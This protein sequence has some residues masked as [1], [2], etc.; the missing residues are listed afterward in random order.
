MP[1]TTMREESEYSLPEDM[2]F[3]GRVLSI[4]SRTIEFTVKKDGRGKKA[5]DKD[6]FDVWEWEF[7][8]DDGPYATLKGY[9]TTESYL[10]NL[11]E[12]RGRTAL[13]RPWCE[14]LIGR[15]IEIG[16][17][18]DTESLIGL[19][20]QFTVVHEEPRP[21]KDGGMFYGCAVADVF[22]VA[23]AAQNLNSE[24]PF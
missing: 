16:E 5:G 22:P 9:G 11:A 2:L 13:A 21:K 20:C 19:P 24:P 14:T 3:P 4:A 6:S 7:S 17:E 10:T 18:F 12:P 15:T 8:I 1:K 23:P